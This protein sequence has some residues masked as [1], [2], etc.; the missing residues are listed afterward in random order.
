LG[1][2][3]TEVGKAYTTTEST[4]EKGCS[5]TQESCPQGIGTNPEEN[6]CHSSAQKGCAE[7]NFEPRFLLRFLTEGCSCT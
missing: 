1:G 7:A 6:D 4:T 3:T 5:R 2:A